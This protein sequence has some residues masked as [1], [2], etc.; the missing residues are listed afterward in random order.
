MF[1]YGYVKNNVF[2]ME[3][4]PSKG[5]NVTNTT[6]IPAAPLL[7]QFWFQVDKVEDTFLKLEH[8]TKVTFFS[9]QKCV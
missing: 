3:G 4:R 9:A 7:A 6:D 2:Q 8:W 1:P 5:E